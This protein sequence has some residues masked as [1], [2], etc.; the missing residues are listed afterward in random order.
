[1]AINFKK[2]VD[3]TQ[4]A[5]TASVLYTAPANTTAQVQDV[6]ICNTSTA[7]KT[8]S[9]YVVENGGSVAAA[10]T[11]IDAK[12]V[13]V[14]QTMTLSDLTGFVLEAG[15]TLRGLASAATSVSVQ[16]SGIEIV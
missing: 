12:P 2:F 3:G 7:A 13:G 4:L 6:T 14:D 15:D 5:T 10:T 1:M 11:V 9:F 8:V 16:A